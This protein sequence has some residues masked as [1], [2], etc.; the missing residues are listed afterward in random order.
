MMESQKSSGEFISA[1]LD[2]KVVSATSAN[3][4]NYLLCT[5]WGINYICTSLGSL[6]P[7]QQ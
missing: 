7:S 2:L 5:T 6:A 4:G 3:S 1:C